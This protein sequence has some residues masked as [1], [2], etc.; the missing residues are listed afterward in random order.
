M[1]LFLVCVLCAVS[2]AVA[3]K[4]DWV[5]NPGMYAGENFVVVAVVKEKKVDK[6][7]DKAEKKAKKGLETL[8]KQKYPKKDVKSSLAHAR[9]EAYWTESEYTYALGLLPLEAIDKNYA[10]QKKMDMARGTALNA[11]KML[12][13]QAKDS[14]VLVMDAEDDIGE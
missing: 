4:P 11:A 14:D 1:R 9:I 6:A 3:Q 8:L 10:A 5:D 7:R 2:S 13:E 12:N